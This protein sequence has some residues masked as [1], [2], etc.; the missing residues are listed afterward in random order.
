MTQRDEIFE[1]L[2]VMT[3]GRAAYICTPNIRSNFDLTKPKEL[4]LASASCL[5]GANPFTDHL[6]RAP[7]LMGTG[8][9]LNRVSSSVERFGN[10]FA[11][12]N[13]YRV[14]WG[15]TRNWS[16]S[17]RR[18]PLY[19]TLSELQ[20]L[21]NELTRLPN[22]ER[23]DF[24]LSNAHLRNLESICQ[25]VTIRPKG[26]QDTDHYHVSC[27]LIGE[28]T[29]ELRFERRCNS[30]HYNF[31][32]SYDLPYEMVG[33]RAVNDYAVKMRLGVSRN[34]PIM[35][36][37]GTFL[38]AYFQLHMCGPEDMVVEEDE[39]LNRVRLFQR[40]QPEEVYRDWLPKPET[41]SLAFDKPGGMSLYRRTDLQPDVKPVKKL[42]DMIAG[43]M[44]NVPIKIEMFDTHESSSHKLEPGVY[45]FLLQEEPYF[46]G[47]MF[48]YSIATSNE[49]SRY[50]VV[51][52]SGKMAAITPSS[53]ERVVTRANISQRELSLPQDT[54]IKNS[55]QINKNF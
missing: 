22:H 28:I 19:D 17:G 39:T 33:Y 31:T 2:Q 52:P 49:L 44:I 14:N 26:E 43:D 20:R 34:T 47:N 10:Y 27:T 35:T 50:R 48:D 18:D 12:T 53:E 3:T 8:L 37:G 15:R 24:Q 1:T 29:D 5:A 55:H 36:S 13:V 6:V 42:E 54:E 30:Y 11:L 45:Q 23:S 40:H 41:L 4:I 16:S 38:D 46:E 32:Y 25:S 7:S 21:S 9:Y 51:L